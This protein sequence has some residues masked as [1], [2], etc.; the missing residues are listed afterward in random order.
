[1]RNRR[2]GLD[3]EP[4]QEDVLLPQFSAGNAGLEPDERSRQKR[5]QGKQKLILF[6]M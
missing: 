3:V 4:E 2:I 5:N 6:K 1:M